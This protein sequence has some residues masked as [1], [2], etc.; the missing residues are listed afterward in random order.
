MDIFLTASSW[1][2]LLLSSSD[3]ARFFPPLSVRDERGAR[4][5]FCEEEEE[6]DDDML[7][8]QHSFPNVQ[9]GLLRFAL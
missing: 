6:D 2:L 4:F 7:C 8:C 5:L 1:L 3:R 9:G